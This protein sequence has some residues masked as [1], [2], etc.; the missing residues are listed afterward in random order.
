MKRE[1]CCLFDIIIY[2]FRQNLLIF[3]IFLGDA[4]GK[5]FGKLIAGVDRLKVFRELISLTVISNCKKKSDW[6]IPSLQ[7][8]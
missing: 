8:F 5:D 6:Q 2:R 7:W 1:V 4:T 3:K